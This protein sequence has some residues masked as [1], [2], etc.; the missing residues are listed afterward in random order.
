MEEY[1]YRIGCNNC[2]YSEERT[3]EYKYLVDTSTGIKCPNCGEEELI[4]TEILSKNFYK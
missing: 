1:K 4:V 2:E 3:F